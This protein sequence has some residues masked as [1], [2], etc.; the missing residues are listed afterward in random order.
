M[1]VITIDSGTV[2]GDGGNIGG[3]LNLDSFLDGGSGGGSSSGESKRG[4]GRPRG[5]GNRNRTA[6]D[7]SGTDNGTVYRTEETPQT[8]VDEPPRRRGRPAGSRAAKKGKA[9]F[10][11]ND[12][13]TIF[14]AIFNVF[15][16]IRGG[17]WAKSMEDVTPFAEA[18]YTQLETGDK[19]TAEAFAKAVAPLQLILSFLWLMAPSLKAEKELY[20]IRKSSGIRSN[21]GYGF[22]EFPTG[23]IDHREGLAI[24]RANAEDYQGQSTNGP[25]GLFATT[26]SLD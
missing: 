25:I 20:E 13:A 17:H 24:Q 14:C 22:E 21:G 16:M 5:S 9:G 3:T 23:P 18:V 4:R 26:N 8:L 10:S 6:D 12:L 15:A 11:A 1:E 7:G 2:G 19:K